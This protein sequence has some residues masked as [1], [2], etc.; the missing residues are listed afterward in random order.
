MIWTHMRETRTTAD[1]SLTVFE[2]EQ[3]LFDRRV[4]SGSLSHNITARSSAKAGKAPNRVDQYSV[5]MDK[6]EDWPRGPLVPRSSSSARDT[7]GRARS[8]SQASF[9]EPINRMWTGSC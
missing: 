4:N 9:G 6:P 3:L 5:S 7:L 8:L 2:I 1:R